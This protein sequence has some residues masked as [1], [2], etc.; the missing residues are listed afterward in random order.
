MKDWRSSE[1]LAF[2][3]WVRYILALI[4]V[5]VAS[6]LHILNSDKFPIIIT[7]VSV[8]TYGALSVVITKASLHFLGPY[9]DSFKSETLA[10]VFGFVLLSVI[11]ALAGSSGSLLWWAI[12]GH[13]MAPIG[14]TLGAG[15]LLGLSPL[16][17]LLG[18]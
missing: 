14:S 9:M 5:L 1:L 13:D 12:H 15:A 16:I 8:I 2:P 18:N 7:F 3:V 17:L 4:S 11:L 10:D 6:A